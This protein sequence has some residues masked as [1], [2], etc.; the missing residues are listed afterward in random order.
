MK[1][2]NTTFG[3]EVREHCPQALAG[4]DRLHAAAKFGRE[5]TDHAHPFRD[6]PTT[7]YAIR[8]D[9]RLLQRAPESL[10]AGRAVKLSELPEADQP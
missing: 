7:R 8:H 9:R 4:D 6:N 10:P 5:A 1:A 3:R 2:V